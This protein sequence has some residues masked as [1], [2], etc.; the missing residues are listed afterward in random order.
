MLRYSRFRWGTEAIFLVVQI[1]SSFP[2]GHEVY[3]K[4][5]EKFVPSWERARTQHEISWHISFYPDSLDPRIRGHGGS[6]Q[7]HQMTHGEGVG[8]K[9]RPIVSL[10]ILMAPNSIWTVFNITYVITIMENLEN[11]SIRKLKYWLRFVIDF[12]GL[13]FWTDFYLQFSLMSFNEWI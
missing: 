10:I 12:S 13:D 7:C 3:G 2:A 9:N 8:V 6:R 1:T 4:T 5:T 11:N